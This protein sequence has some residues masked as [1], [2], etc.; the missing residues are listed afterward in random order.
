MT[1][2]ERVRDFTI[3]RY[4]PFAIACATGISLACVSGGTYYWYQLYKNKEA[5]KT[6]GLHL[7]EYYKEKQATSHNWDALVD[8]FANAGETM[9]GTGLAPY[10]FAY[11]AQSLFDKGDYNAGLR[12]LTKAVEMMPAN[13]PFFHLFK[14]K[15][16]LIMIDA[17]DDLVRQQGINLLTELARSKDNI[18]KDY[19]LY[20]LGYFY[21]TRA[22]LDEAKKIWQELVDEY[23]HENAAPSPWALLAEQ[24]LPSIL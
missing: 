5:Q 16:A 7:D 6:L 21:W 15:M 17:Q 23:R 13:S 20:N 8:K 3:Q 19:A 24:R 1:V 4:M 9:S 22:N 14:T 10:S 12:A 18:N 11:Q 2:Y